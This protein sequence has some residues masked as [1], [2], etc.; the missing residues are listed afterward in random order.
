MSPNATH[1]LVLTRS[2]AAA[3]A[4]VYAAFLDPKLLAAWFAPRGYTVPEAKI[5]PVQEGGYRVTMRTFSGQQFAVAGCYR[6]LSPPERLVFTWVWQDGPLAALGETLVTVTLREQGDRTEVELRHSGFPMPDAR[7]RHADGW[8]QCLN[9]LVDL[10]DRAGTAASLTLFGAPRSSYV[11]SVVMGLVEKGLAYRHEPF[12]FQTPEQLAVHPF[13][14]IPALRD[15]DFTLFETSAILRY[16]EESF[17]GPSLV[18]LNP[19]LRAKMEQ[20]VSAVSS[21]V[22]DPCVRNYVLQFLFAQQAQREPDRAIIERALPEMQRVLGIF[23][24]GYTDGPFL[25]GPALSM[26]DL[27][28]APIIASVRAFPEG[29][30]IV[31]SLPKLQ[32]AHQLMCDRKSFQAAHAVF[33]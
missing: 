27:L 3:R 10:L 25:A 6:E 17:E 2:I 9:K 18:P 8:N 33:A 16:L 22:Y 31:D 21:Y 30:A 11:R 1:E 4:R 23:E 7:E 5:D 14:R 29:K 19:R 20:W 28:L 15:G 32:R 13:G 12:R 26:A 24:A